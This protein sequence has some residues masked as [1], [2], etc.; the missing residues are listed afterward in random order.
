MLRQDEAAL[1]ALQDGHQWLSVR[2]DGKTAA[3][4]RNVPEEVDVDTEALRA[5][6]QTVLASDAMSNLRVSAFSK[7]AVK[8]S[9]LTKLKPQPKPEASEP[10]QQK[11]PKRTLSPEENS[12]TSEEQVSWRARLFHQPAWFVSLS[13]GLCLVAAAA[14]AG[15]G[16]WLLIS[17]SPSQAAETVNMIPWKADSSKLENL[18]K[19]QSESQGGL[20]VP[21]EN[22]ETEAISLLAMAKS[23][24]DQAVVPAGLPEIQKEQVGRPDPFAPLIQEGIGDEMVSPLAQPKD[25]LDDV[26]YT[27]FVGDVNAKDKVALIQVSNGGVPQTL[28]KKAG[29]TISVDGEKLILKSISKD[30]VVLSVRGKTRR[31]ALTPFVDSAP[32]SNGASQMSA[33]IAVPSASSSGTAGTLPNLTERSEKPNPTSTML[34]EPG[35]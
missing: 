29:E 34:M 26:M 1:N 21:K 32:A 23:P 12:A 6:Y 30:A 19:L 20:I 31:L 10:V 24:L 14:Y 2:R 13:I 11:M 9:L 17:G 25:I 16:Y 35:V 7:P 18:Q 4:L 27:G 5:A 15:L 3:E 22:M 28:V 8:P 33:P